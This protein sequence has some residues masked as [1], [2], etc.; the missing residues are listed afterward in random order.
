MLFFDEIPLHEIF[1]L[2]KFFVNMIPAIL[3]ILTVHI[4]IAVG[5]L[6]IKSLSSLIRILQSKEKKWAEIKGFQ[7]TER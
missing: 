5:R 3:I 7:P 6:L 1:D 2:N 4:S